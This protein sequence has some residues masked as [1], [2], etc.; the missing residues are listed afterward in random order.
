MIQRTMLINA[1]GASEGCTKE[2]NAYLDRIDAPDDLKYLDQ[3]L[4]VMACAIANMREIC[5]DD[6]EYALNVWDDLTQWM[7]GYI[8]QRLDENIEHYADVE[9]KTIKILRG[10]NKKNP[11]YV[12]L[13]TGVANA[14]FT[15]KYTLLKTVYFLI[16]E[17]LRTACIESGVNV[18][19]WLYVCSKEIRILGEASYSHIVELLPD[20]TMT[21]EEY[22]SAII[23]I[24]KS[25]KNE[26]LQNIIKDIGVAL[27][28][29]KIPSGSETGEGGPGG[30][31][32]VRGVSPWR[33]PMSLVVVDQASEADGYAI[34][35][36][37]VNSYHTNLRKEMGDITE[38]DYVGVSTILNMIPPSNSHEF[39]D[40]KSEALKELGQRNAMAMKN[41]LISPH[42]SMM[43]E[44]E[45]MK[46]AS[47]MFDY[48]LTSGDEMQLET[49]VIISMIMLYGISADRCL[50]LLANNKAPSPEDRDTQLLY[51][52]EQSMIYQRVRKLTKGINLSKEAKSQAIV[53]EQF[54]PLSVP[55]SLNNA[56][57]TL[58][59]RRRKIKKRGKIKL[60]THAN[61]NHVNRKIRE[62]ANTNKTS[63]ALRNF[64][65]FTLAGES[66]SISDA[67][68]ITGESCGFAT[69]R[70]HYTTRAMYGLQQRHANLINA[71]IEDVRFEMEHAQD[72]IQDWKIDEQMYDNNNL[73][74][75][76]NI[77]PKRE[78]IKNL[79][80]NLLTQI[81]NKRNDVDW[82]EYHNVYTAYT[83]LYLDYAT[84]ARA[85]NSKYPL[86]SSISLDRD[87]IV[88]SDKDATDYY[89][90]RIAPL[91]Q[92]L[93]RH[94]KN[95]LKHRR[96][97]FE[98]LSLRSDELIEKLRLT[99][100]NEITKWDK[101]NIRKLLENK[102]GLFFY[103]DSNYMVRNEIIKE[104][105]KVIL[106][107]FSL[108]L[109]TNRHYNR[110]WLCES[111][112]NH[113]YIDALY[114]HWQ[115]GEEP[116]GKYSTLSFKA[117]IDTLLPLIAERLKKDGWTP[118][119]GMK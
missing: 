38:D 53:V 111:S 89:N 67:M 116:Y 5:V 81:K 69:T 117:V 43:G 99:T 77:T 119:V 33:Y 95:Y 6:N 13:W 87:C 51:T 106:D 14:D 30:Y 118:V 92:D 91:P 88:I 7:K 28:R 42:R 36:Y 56:F 16:W 72:K 59:E 46:I 4:E 9:D 45:V 100:T 34:S 104:T 25:H 96:I 24:N 93:K 57:K 8:T 110:T 26:I 18:E 10:K 12:L 65:F 61:A 50:A 21:I 71:L 86:I 27:G 32:E 82:W 60:F 66:S 40:T 115:Y 55:P 97:V 114:G 94:I 101:T 23:E 47:W 1:H 70:L 62:V 68:L 2:I 19:H 84:S 49:Y 20:K 48:N 80:N 52:D 105:K 113:I 41:Q 102:H 22:H 98:R 107:W 63:A 83:I 31:H 112:M 109:N 85:V 35:E 37:K 44:W 76:A 17:K 78:V 58:Y 79:I 75:G 29:I 39:S 74:V 3:V 73:Y 11:L 15:E 103:L 54:F 108:P 90:T 64:V